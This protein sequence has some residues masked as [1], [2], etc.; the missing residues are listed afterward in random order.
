MNTPHRPVLIVSALVAALGPLIGN[1][2]YA[3]PEATG[4][5][6]VDELDGGLPAVAYVAYSL[7]LVGFVALGVFMACLVVTLW[8]PAPVAAVTTAVIGSSMLAV[9]IG[10]IAPTMAL[11]TSGEGI[12]AATAEVIVGIGDA[13]FIVAGFLLCLSLAAAGIGLL[14]TDFPRWLAWWPVVCGGLGTVAGMVGILEPDAYVFI[15]FLLLMV[16][17]IALGITTAISGRDQQVLAPEP[18]TAAQ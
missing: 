4:Q 9:K 15:P 10:S 11:R 1:G 12:D 13:A 18:V 8:R 17:M 16:W 6:L 5:Q 3:G 2:L 14:K 7:E